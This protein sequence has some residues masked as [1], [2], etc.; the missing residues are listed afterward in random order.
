MAQ[1]VVMPQLGNTVESCLVTTWLV[2]V[3]DVVDAATLLC[4]IETDKSAMEVPSGVAAGFPPDVEASPTPSGGE[5]RTPIWDEL[6]DRWAA[7][8]PLLARTVDEEADRG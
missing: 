4:E 7:L 6:A 2:K 8:Q 1:V 3:G 5:S